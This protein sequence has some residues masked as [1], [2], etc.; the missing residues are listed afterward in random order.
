[1]SAL[2]HFQ[3]GVARWVGQHHVLLDRTEILVL[4]S[5]LL[6]LLGQALA[7]QQLWHEI[8]TTGFTKV[9]LAY[10]PQPM[11]S[12]FAD[13][14]MANNSWQGFEAWNQTFDDEL[15]AIDIQ[16]IRELLD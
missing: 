3:N 11:T 6:C 12:D 4:S 13:T 10:L 5:R 15:D 2:R 7:Y 14:K 1:M 8:K 16:E 9:R